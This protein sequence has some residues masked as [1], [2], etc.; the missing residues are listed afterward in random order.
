VSDFRLTRYAPSSVHTW[1]TQF[2]GVHVRGSSW[3]STLAA[4]RTPAGPAQNQAADDQR[5]TRLADRASR[6]LKRQRPAQGL[7]VALNHTVQMRRSSGIVI[8]PG[9]SIIRSALACWK[10]FPSPKAPEKRPP[11]CKSK[12]VNKTNTIESEAQIHGTLLNCPF[13]RYLQK[14]TDAEIRAGRPGSSGR[15]PVTVHP[16]S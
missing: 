13:L 5:S 4:A 9:L 12:S 3:V 10:Q 2:M 1:P 7:G 11:H 14:I 6:T 15:N 16:I 8:D